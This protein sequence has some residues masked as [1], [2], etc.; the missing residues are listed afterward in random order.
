MT[1]CYLASLFLSV[2]C[3]VQH[4]TEYRPKTTLALTYKGPALWNNLPHDLKMLQFN[5]T[6]KS[7]LKNYLIDN[8]NNYA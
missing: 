7:K 3:N 8:N 4:W 2:Q 6:F 1:K 5:S